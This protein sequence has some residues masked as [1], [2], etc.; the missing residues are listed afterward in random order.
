MMPNH[1]LKLKQRCRWHTLACHT[2][3]TMQVHIL[4][5]VSYYRGTEVDGKK[6]KEKEKS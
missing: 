4:H 2:V 3:V 6:R 1:S 5:V